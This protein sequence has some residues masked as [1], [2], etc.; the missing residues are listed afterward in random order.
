MSPTIN[1]VTLGVADLNRS[2]QF[3]VTGLDCK[4]DQD[5]PQFVSFTLGEGSSAL[6]LYPRRALAHDAGVDASGS[7]F[8]GVTLNYFVETDQR[9]DEVLAA[10]VQAGGAV[11]RAAQRAQWGGYF[12]YFRDRKSVV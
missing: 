9:V 2:K 5:Q 11:A 3:Y 12:G 4:I 10:A 6:S 1:A 7:G 8:P